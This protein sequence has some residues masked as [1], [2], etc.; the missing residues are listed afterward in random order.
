[1]K[2]QVWYTDF[3]I[4][5]LIFSITIT[6]YFYYSNYVGGDEGN[7]ESFLISE[8]KSISSYLIT[9]GYPKN[10]S[11]AN[12][13]TVGLTDGN[14]RINNQK[15]QAFNS[16]NYEERRSFIHTSKDYIFFLEYLN[17]TRYNILCEDPPTCDAWNASSYLIQQ[18]RLAIHN[19]SI[20]KLKIYMYQ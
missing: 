20:V 3:M 17:G 7:I 11:V 10:W 5:I 18:T 4:A 2:A 9:E 15:L 6:A 13:S 8:G 19:G 14:Y 16:W 12:V 1:M